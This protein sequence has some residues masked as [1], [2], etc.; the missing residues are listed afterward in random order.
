MNRGRIFA[1]IPAAGYSRR[2]G[3]PKLVLPI[4]DSTVMGRVLT[5]LL[6]CVTAIT[7]V[8]RRDDV[9]L[10]TVIRAHGIEPVLPRIDP[11]DMRASI[12]CGLREI[13]RRFQ[14]TAEEA[15]LL[16]PADHPVVDV[17]L[18]HTVVDRWREVTTDVLIPAYQGRRGHPLIAR[19]STV[20]AVRRLPRDVGVNAWLRSPST[21]VTEWAIDDPRILCD[22]DRPED[23][24]RLLAYANRLS[25]KPP[26]PAFPA[27]PCG[28]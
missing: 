14:P 16:L 27:P 23:Y 21:P 12:E 26:P 6:P 17:E 24:E 1:V 13:E 10:Q 15:W 20:E 7:V 9:N 11:P 5:A 25:E 3:Q 2:M 4:G 28:A 8:V 19:W 22:L 18:M